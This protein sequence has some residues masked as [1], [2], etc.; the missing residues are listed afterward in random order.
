[1]LVQ[2]SLMKQNLNTMESC[3]KFIDF[4]NEAQFQCL[5]LARKFIETILKLKCYCYRCRKRNGKISAKR[6]CRPEG[7]RVQR[8][9]DINEE[10]LNQLKQESNNISIFPCDLAD[11]NAVKEMMDE[12]KH[13]MGPID[14]VTHAGAVMPMGKVKDLDASSINSLMR[15][16]YEGTV[17]MASNDSIHA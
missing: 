10:N 3:S 12:V 6:L 15:I 9:I 8:R 2:S 5:Y 13:Q 16:N 1:M 14:R 17:N 4:S 11:S 7:V